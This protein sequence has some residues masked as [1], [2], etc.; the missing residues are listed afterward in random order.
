[1]RERSWRTFSAPA[2][3][4][5]SWG[6]QGSKRHTETDRQGHDRGDQI[7]VQAGFRREDHRRHRRR[8]RGDQD[9]DRPFQPGE[10]QQPGDSPSQ[11][12]AASHSQR[13]A[14]QG[15]VPGSSHSLETDREAEDQARERG[16]REMDRRQDRLEPGGQMEARRLSWPA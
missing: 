6:S 3:R 7:F 2:S 9:H 13:H 4:A 1:M 5:A 10:I 16:R 11:Q 15:Q 14:Q 8:H 12:E